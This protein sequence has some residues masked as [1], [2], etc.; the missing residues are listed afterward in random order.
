MVWSRAPHAFQVVLGGKESTRQ[1]RR[2]IPGPGRS[3][4]EGNGNPL[5][6]SCLENPMDRGALV[7]FS[8][9]G[10]RVRHHW[11][12]WAYNMGKPQR[13]AVYRQRAEGLSRE[14]ETGCFYVA[15]KGKTRPRRNALGRNTWIQHKAL[16]VA[17]LSCKQQKPIFCIFSMYKSS[18]TRF[19]KMFSHC[20][21]CLFT[22]S[23]LSFEVQNAFN[24]HEV[25]FAH[26]LLLL[27]MVLVSYLRNDCLIQ[28]H[29]DLP[30]CFLLRVLQF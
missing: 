30:L 23:M 18:D 12:D 4:G 27:L 7:G 21:G 14:R 10:C 3:P 5:Q 16:S 17:V 28:A 29:G 24:V 9:W 26:L 22:L 11:S 13:V 6:Y 2:R 8:S 25:Q 15:L 19:A 20:F 1:R